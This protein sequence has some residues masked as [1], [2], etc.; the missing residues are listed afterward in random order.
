VGKTYRFIASYWHKIAFDGDDSRVP[1]YQIMNLRS[2]LPYFL[3]KRGLPFNYPK[4]ESSITTDVAIIGGGI[5]GAL[6]AHHL[7]E[8]GIECVIIDGRSIGM[9]STSAST[10]LLQYEID[11][12]LSTLTELRGYD[13]ACRSFELC[14][15]SIISIQAISK[16]IGVDYFEPR[17]SLYFS[18]NKKD[19]TF[20]EREF[21]MRKEAGFNV[22]LL[23]KEDIAK[24]FG[25]TSDVAI[26]S[27]HGAQIDAY[28]FTHDL[29]Q[30]NMKQ[31]LRVFDRSMVEKI[32]HSGSSIKL[33]TENGNTI[34]TS[35]LV[36]ATGYEVVNFLRKKIVKL[37]ST[38]AIISEHLEQHPFPLRDDTLF[39][40]TADPYLYMTA[41]DGRIMIGGRDEQ[42]YNPAKRDKLIKKKSTQLTHDF[43]KM[44]PHIPFVPEF[45]WS[46]TFGSTQDGLPYIGTTGNRKNVFYALGFGGNGITFSEVGARIITDLI[47]GRQNK[48]ARLFDF[49]R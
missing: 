29:I 20:I 14:K 35:Y 6:M 22:E 28:S 21:E 23:Y 34:T 45:R 9:G 17:K 8:A 26:L 37:L 10:S 13:D 41:L 1:Y 11:V 27:H 46:G 24:T 30:H 3:L 31:G 44:L 38:Y 16:Q 49:N 4:L 42:F 25:L 19:V 36:N 33:K 2:G 15:D 18:A 12:P 5:S 47:R 43:K 40:N 32:M 39:W 7:V 48:D